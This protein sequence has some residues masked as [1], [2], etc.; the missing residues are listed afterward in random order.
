M[1][2]VVITIVAA[3]PRAADAQVPLSFQIGWSD[4][5]NHYLIN[6]DGIVGN[7]REATVTIADASA[8]IEEAL[9]LGRADHPRSLRERR[10]RRARACATRSSGRCG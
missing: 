10:A 5:G 4:F 9:A 1:L 7:P 6:P 3:P 8:A 2:A